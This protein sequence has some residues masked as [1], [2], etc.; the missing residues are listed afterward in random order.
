MPA[1]LVV[2]PGVHPK[3]MP[4]PPEGFEDQVL[5]AEGEHRDEDEDGEEPRLRIGPGFRGL[6]RKGTGARADVTTF[7]GEM[8]FSTAPERDGGQ[9]QGGEA[10]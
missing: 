10:R 4:A 7:C 2:S 1:R 9:R 6:W 5:R 3:T 8:A